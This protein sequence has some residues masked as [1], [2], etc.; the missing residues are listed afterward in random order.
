MKI[1]LLGYL[2]LAVLTTILLGACGGGGGTT[3]SGKTL[4]SIAVQPTNPSIALGTNMQ[5]TATGTYSD[6]TTQDLTTAVTWSSSAASVATISNDA[7]SNGK[8][9]AVSAGTTTIT[10]TSSGSI[11]GST[12]LTVQPT[13]MN[14][15]IALTP[16]ITSLGALQ[17]SLINDPGATYNNDIAAIN[18]AQGQT[19]D[20]IPVGNSLGVGIISSSS[21]N[22]LATPILSLSYAIS[23][24]TLPGV[25]VSPT[26]IVASDG[27]GQRIT[28][29][30]ANFVVNV[31]YN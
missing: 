12:L 14:V 29:T 23:A 19:V 24:G 28:L 10:A 1:K 21:F 5:F 4:I 6:N 22:T 8:A 20:A 31:T 25:Q 2:V 3:S 17:F 27:T 16:P 7:G 18:G 30:P 11:S 9:T 26:G 13:K 15:T